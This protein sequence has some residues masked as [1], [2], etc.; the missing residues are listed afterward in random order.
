MA[1]KDSNGGKNGKNSDAANTVIGMKTARQ[2]LKD[3]HRALESNL[4]RT[5]GDARPPGDTS[6]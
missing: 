4:D 2:M 5:G 6:T 3:D 1:E